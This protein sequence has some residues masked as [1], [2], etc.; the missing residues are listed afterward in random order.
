MRG[1]LTRGEG[2]LRPEYTCKGFVPY[3]QVDQPEF[4][5]FPKNA[6]GCPKGKLSG[7]YEQSV[8][9]RTEYGHAGDH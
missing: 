5:L 3:P 8:K 4:M 2:E 7:P 9:D 1:E 6:K